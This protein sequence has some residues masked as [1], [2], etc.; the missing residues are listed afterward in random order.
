MHPGGGG[1]RLPTAAVE[2]EAQTSDVSFSFSPLA[3]V[4]AAAAAA[5]QHTRLYRFIFNELHSVSRPPHC[6][7]AAAAA[8]KLF[9]LRRHP[10]RRR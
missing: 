1:C 5:G 10:H 8:V 2:R 3:G 7:A 6:L 9:V 4:A